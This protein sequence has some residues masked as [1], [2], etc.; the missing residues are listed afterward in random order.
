MLEDMPSNVGVQR[1]L[2]WARPGGRRTSLR[3]LSIIL[4]GPGD[5]R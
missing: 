4:D 3:E 2:A 1:T 5:S